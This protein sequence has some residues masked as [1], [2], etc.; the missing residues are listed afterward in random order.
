MVENSQTFNT[1]LPV[2]VTQIP[3]RTGYMNLYI[4]LL[5]LQPK[6]QL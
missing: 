3:L 6:I 2:T 5:T 1:Q 4:K